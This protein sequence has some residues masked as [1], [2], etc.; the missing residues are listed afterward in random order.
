MNNISI[1]EQ[2]WKYWKKEK[3][4]N[5]IRENSCWQNFCRFCQFWFSYIQRCFQKFLSFHC[6]FYYIEMMLYYIVLCTLLN[7]TFYVIL[8]H[9]VLEILVF[10]LFCSIFYYTEIMFIITLVYYIHCHYT[11]HVTLCYIIFEIFRNFVTF[12]ILHFIL[13]RLLFITLY[14]LLHW[15]IN[16]YI[17]DET[18]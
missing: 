17:D 12:D 6:T 3:N 14:I 7:Y 2:Q 15:N 4:N 8:C 10:M 18:I 1:T 5:I 11:F 13:L 16:R 9:V